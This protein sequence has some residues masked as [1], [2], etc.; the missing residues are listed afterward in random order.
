MSNQTVRRV[1]YKH[2]IDF[3]SV[4]SFRQSLRR[5]ILD[6]DYIVLIMGTVVSKDSVNKEIQI[7]GAHN[8]GITGDNNIAFMFN[9]INHNISTIYNE[10]IHEIAQVYRLDLIRVHSVSTFLLLTIILVIIQCFNS[11]YS[12]KKCEIM[13]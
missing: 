4:L 12:L 11:Q 3:L 10:L 1:S 7:A 5:R 8:I 9:G 13:K 6:L 2:R